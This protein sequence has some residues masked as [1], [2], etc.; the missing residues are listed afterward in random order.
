MQLISRSSILE[1]R[2]HSLVE[3]TEEVTKTAVFGFI[4]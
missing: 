3:N 4:T 1:Q 2:L